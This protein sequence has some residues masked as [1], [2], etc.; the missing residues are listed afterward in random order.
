M[1]WVRAYFSSVDDIN[2]PR[3]TTNQGR[4]REKALGVQY[5]SIDSWIIRVWN[6][7]RPINYASRGVVVSW[8]GWGGV[9]DG[10]GDVEP[11]GCG[12]VF[13]ILFLL[14]FIACTD[15]NFRKDAKEWPAF[16]FDVLCSCFH[17]PSP[18]PPLCPC[19]CVSINH[20]LI[21]TALPAHNEKVKRPIILRL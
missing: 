13:L 10:G 14:Y 3:F 17:P 7:V 21:I 20:L 5:R 19:R 1:Q 12:I 11:H 18:P 6:S 16:Y 4:L 2:I 15:I 8:V 9:H